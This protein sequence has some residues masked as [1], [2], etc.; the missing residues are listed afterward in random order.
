MSPFYE[1]LASDRST[2]AV[3]EYPV[4]IGDIF[5]ALHDYQRTHGKRVVGGFRRIPPPKGEVVYPGVVRAA[6][7][8]GK[9]SAALD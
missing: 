2:R 4:P 8:P 3:I 5:V 1:S 7:L 6:W 9:G